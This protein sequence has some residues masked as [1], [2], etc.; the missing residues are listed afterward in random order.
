MEKVERNWKADIRQPETAQG[1]R[2][3]SIIGNQGVLQL[4]NESCTAFINQVIIPA[5][6]EIGMGAYS[7]KLLRAMLS[8]YK[9][10]DGTGYQYLFEAIF[11]W[12]EAILAKLIQSRKFR[13]IIYDI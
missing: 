3:G 8:K 13:R 5:C 10:S 7:V 6:N 4:M 12:Y 2:A 11:K 1:K 9:D